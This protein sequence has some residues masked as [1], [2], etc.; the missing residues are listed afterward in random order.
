[1]ERLSSHTIYTNTSPVKSLHNTTAMPAQGPEQDIRQAGQNI[2]G[3]TD[4][5]SSNV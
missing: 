4:L 5:I 3:R 2:F 1:M